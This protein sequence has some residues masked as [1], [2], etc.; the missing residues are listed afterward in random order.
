MAETTIVVP[1]AYVKKVLVPPSVS[2]IP[3]LEPII[4]INRKSRVFIVVPLHWP[5]ARMACRCGDSPTSRPPRFM[6]R[7]VVRSFVGRR[8][9]V[10]KLDSARARNRMP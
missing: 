5:Q 4:Q 3:R 1:S 9:V 6:R 8:N 2:P 7:A 10:R